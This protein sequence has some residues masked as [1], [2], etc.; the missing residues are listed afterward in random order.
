MLIEQKIWTSKSSAWKILKSF[1]SP[2]KAHL[3]MVFGSTKIFKN[4]MLMSEVKAF[5]PDAIFIGCSTSGEIATAFIEDESVVCT[6]IHFEKSTVK[7]TCVAVDSSTESV[8]AGEQLMSQIPTEN[9]KHIFVLSEGLNI[10]GTKLVEGMQNKLPPSVNVTGGL[11]GDGA[12]FQE[13][14]LLSEKGVGKN[15]IVAVGIYGN[16][17]KVGYGSFGGWDIFGVERLVTK[18]ESNVL[19]EIDNSPAL[20]LY[21]SFLGEQ[22]AQLPSSGLLFPL[23]VRT[24]SSEEPVVRTIL[25]I[26]EANQSLTFAGDIPEGSYVKL[27]KANVDHLVDGANTAA[28]RA[29]ETLGIAEPE[30]AILV[31]CVGRKLVMKQMA[32]EEIEAV[33]EVLGDA[34]ITGFYSYGEIAPFAKGGKC[35]LHNQTMTVTVFSEK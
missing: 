31:S 18:S 9:L 25:A 5:Y 20:S 28:K 14:F 32:E 30:L 7:T 2:A 22:S 6:A 35:S 19:F 4:E 11:A 15:K 10:N 17:F 16:D 8:K 1:S 26:D 23:S 3:V 29:K 12:N 13:T 27:M 34:T 33:Q 21:K 24:Q